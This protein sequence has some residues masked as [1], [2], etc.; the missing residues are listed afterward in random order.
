MVI[1]FPIPYPGEAVTSFVSRIVEIYGCS[2]SEHRLEA[3][4]WNAA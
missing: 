4:L 3:L 1:T 2:G